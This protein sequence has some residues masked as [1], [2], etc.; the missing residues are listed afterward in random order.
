M[1]CAMGNKEITHVLL[2]DFVCLGILRSLATPIL[3]PFEYVAV[4]FPPAPQNQITKTMQIKANPNAHTV[5]FPA[6]KE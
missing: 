4:L 1:V 6:R 5:V 2:I 3:V